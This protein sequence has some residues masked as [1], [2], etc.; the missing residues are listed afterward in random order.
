MRYGLTTCLLDDGYFMTEISGYVYGDIVNYD[1]LSQNL[2]YPLQSRPTEAWKNGLW[3]RDYQY[4]IAIVNPK[5]NGTQTNVALDG[6]FRKINGT[7]DT[8]VNNGATGVT[9][10]TLNARDGIILL[11]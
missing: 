3:R 10:I 1:E 2:G 6:T 11:R 4:G 9:T 8:T 5:G 7:Q